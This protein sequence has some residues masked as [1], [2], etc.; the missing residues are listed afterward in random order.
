MVTIKNLERLKNNDGSVTFVNGD[1]AIDVRGAEIWNGNPI[2]IYERNWT[3]AQNFVIKDRG[4]EWVS[5]HSALN[6]HYCLD[7]CIYR[8][9]NGTK[10]L[11]WEYKGSTNQKFKLA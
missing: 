2:Q 8:T 11:L 10:I 7:V 4:N 5:I 6:Q 1:K 3:K 9:D